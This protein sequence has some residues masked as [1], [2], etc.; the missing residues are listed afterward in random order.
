MREALSGYHKAL[1]ESLGRFI[2][3][4]RFDNEIGT[5]ICTTNAI[6]SIDARLR[7]SSARRRKPGQSHR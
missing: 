2:P 4:L 3:F 6:E 1:G 5:I 7:G